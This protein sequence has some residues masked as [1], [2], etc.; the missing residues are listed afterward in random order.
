MGE[1]ELPNLLCLEELGRVFEPHPNSV[2]GSEDGGTF[3][4]VAQFT[5]VPLY[6]ESY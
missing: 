5:Y 3:Y 2:L 4:V 6:L 1:A